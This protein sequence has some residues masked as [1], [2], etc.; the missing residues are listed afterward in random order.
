[1]GNVSANRQGSRPQRSFAVGRFIAEANVVAT[2]DEQL[3]SSGGPFVLGRRCTLV[4][5][6]VFLLRECLLGHVDI[7]AMS[8]LLTWI[9]MLHQRRRPDRLTVPFSEPAFGLRIRT[10]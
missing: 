2:L 7:S 5:A 9:E 1:M 6:L 8:H 10:G 4:D 3:A